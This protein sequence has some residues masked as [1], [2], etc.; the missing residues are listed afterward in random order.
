[1]SPFQSATKIEIISLELPTSY[2]L[3]PLRLPYGLKIQEAK[4]KSNSR[5]ILMNNTSPGN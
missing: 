4:E 1:M 5:I 3:V 2:H